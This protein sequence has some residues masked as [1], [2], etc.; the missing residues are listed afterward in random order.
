M[1]YHI[2]QFTTVAN[3]FFVNAVLCYLCPTP[4]NNEDNNEYQIMQS[5]YLGYF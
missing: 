3:N 1:V 4:D 2:P 5:G